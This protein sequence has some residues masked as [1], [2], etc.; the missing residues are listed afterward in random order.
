[1]GDLVEDLLKMTDELE[2]YHVHGFTGNPRGGSTQLDC[3]C[4]NSRLMSFQ[5]RPCFISFAGAGEL[6]YGPLCVYR[7][8][9]PRVSHYYHSAVSADALDDGACV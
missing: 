2:T 4:D 9:I 7:N 5:C 8:N 1:M 3:S 6:V